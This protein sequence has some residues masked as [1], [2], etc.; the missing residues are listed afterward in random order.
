MTRLDTV[1]VNQK[2]S[3]YKGNTYA[4]LSEEDVLFNLIEEAHENAI[5]SGGNRR[6]FHMN[7]IDNT[8]TKVRHNRMFLLNQPIEKHCWT[9]A[10]PKVLARAKYKIVVIIEFQ[11]YLFFL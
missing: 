3:S 4:V 8:G 10:S 1:F 2:V 9:Q 5:L 6:G 11:D 7:A